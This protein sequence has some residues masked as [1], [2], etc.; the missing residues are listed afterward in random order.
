MIAAALTVMNNQRKP[1]KNWVEVICLNC[2]V[3]FKVMPCVIKVG[4][5]KYCTSRCRNIIAGKIATLNCNGENNRNWKGGLTNNRYAYKLKDKQRYPE[6]HRAREAVKRAKKSGKL[7]A[8]PCFNCGE[9]NVEAH[10]EDYSKPLVVKWM[11]VK[12]HHAL[13]H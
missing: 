10:H 11:C 1:T 13:H 4:K 12:C 5:G 2:K 6:H 3:Y 7:I 8:E 9:K